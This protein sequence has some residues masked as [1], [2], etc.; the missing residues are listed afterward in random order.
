M[1]SENGVSISKYTQYWGETPLLFTDTMFVRRERPFFI[2]EVKQE[3]GVNKLVG[4]EEVCE[5]IWLGTWY[6][7][8]ASIR[9]RA[10]GLS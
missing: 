4:F 9:P 7:L 2:A 6:R 5:V 3:V 8:S 10:E 1:C